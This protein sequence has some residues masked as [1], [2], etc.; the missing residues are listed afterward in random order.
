MP[1]I[2]VTFSLHEVL[3]QHLGNAVMACVQLS[4][5]WNGVLIIRFTKSAYAMFM[6]VRAMP[7]CASCPHS[8]GELNRWDVNLAPQ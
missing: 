8:C 3:Q 4:S 1:L 5:H 7:V 2:P 6:Y